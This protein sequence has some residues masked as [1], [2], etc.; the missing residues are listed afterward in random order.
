M[1]LRYRSREE[2][3]SWLN[4]LLQYDPHHRAAHRALA[5]Y[6]SKV[7]ETDLAD[8]HQRA[9]DEPEASRGS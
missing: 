3:V 2:G 9:A 7:G 1:F 8:Q 4:S 5:D 6:Y